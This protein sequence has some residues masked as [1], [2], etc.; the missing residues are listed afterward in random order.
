M[1][2]YISVEQALDLVNSGDHIVVALGASEPYEFLSTLHTIAGRAK[3]V[4]VTN[5][6]SPRGYD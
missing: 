5:G 1:G 2:K 3:N 4:T 6:L